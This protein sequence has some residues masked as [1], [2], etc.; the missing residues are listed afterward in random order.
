MQKQILSL[1]DYFICYSLLQKFDIVF[2]RTEEISFF[3]CLFDTS[4]T[5]LAA[6]KPV[7]PSLVSSV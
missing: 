6:H 2:I 4:L 7:L 1:S 3:Q 5:V